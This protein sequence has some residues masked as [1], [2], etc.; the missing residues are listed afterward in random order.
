MNKEKIQARIGEIQT[1]REEIKALGD[2]ATEADATEFSALVDEQAKLLGQLET[3]NKAE[4]IDVKMA[5]SGVPSTVVVMGPAAE[6]QKYSLGEYLVDIARAT[7]GR[8]PGKRFDSLQQ[9]FKAAATGMSEAVPSDGGFLVG[10]DMVNDMMLR[11]YNNGQLAQR[12]SRAPVSTNS[13]SLTINGIDES[14]RA[15]GSRHGG[16]QS[17]WEGEADEITASK[18][19]FAPVSLKLNKV[20][21]AYYVTDELLQDAP[22]LT[23]IVNE[24]VGDELA[25]KLDDALIRGSGAGRPLGLLYNPALVSVAKQAGQH[26]DTIMWE[27]IRDM[28]AAIWA[29][30]RKNSIWLANDET[31]PQLMEMVKPTGTGGVAVWLPA[32]VALNQ[33]NDSLLGRPVIYP[34]QCSALGDKGDIFL[35]DFSQVQLIEKGGIQG[36]SSIHVRFLQNEQVFRFVYRVDAQSK[37]KS[38]LTPY[39]GAVSKSPFVT[40]AERA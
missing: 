28:Y 36:A 5:A 11:V 7:A 31:I 22:A 19:K 33:P 40:L 9:K 13:N 38:A 27:N 3:I 8:Q 20:T 30:S 18:P 23:A 17:Y 39:K 34:E 14:S 29:G 24:A 26:P 6:G 2:K 12:C 10:T 15:N 25:F 16:I 21:A 37:W 4:E 1:R 35:A 32:N